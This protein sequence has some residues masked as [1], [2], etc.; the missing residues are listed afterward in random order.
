MYTARDS[1]HLQK[2]VKQ[3][4][5]G[6]WS[7]SRRPTDGQAEPAARI[8]VVASTAGE[9]GRGAQLAAAAL[10]DERA[11]EAEAG[12]LRAAPL[13]AERSAKEKAD[14]PAAAAEPEAKDAAAEVET[15]TPR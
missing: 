5:A 14:R 10:E 12:R 3:G 1:K 2:F 4:D 9:R 13:E 15:A 11:A 8:D 6:R 7:V